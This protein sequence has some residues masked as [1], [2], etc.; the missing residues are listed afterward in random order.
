LFTTWLSGVEVLVANVVLPLYT[1]VMDLVPAP[2]VVVVK[3]ATPTLSVTVPSAAVPFLKVTVPVGV[4]H[5]EDTV[6][7]KVSDCPKVLGFRLEV[8]VVAVGSLLMTSLRIP[9]VLT[10]KLASP[11]YVEVMV[12]V[13]AEGNVLLR[14]ACPPLSVTMPKVAP[15]F[16]NVTVPD[17]VPP[18]WP[19]TVAVKVM[20]WLMSAGLLEETTVVVVV[21]LFT[22]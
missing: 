13:P 18:N 2:K 17:G 16:L 22:T 19:A 3:W 15:P 8:I 4:P 9:E 10:V 7:L 12:L 20:A 1:A 21:S 14:L 5:A 6:A 11:E